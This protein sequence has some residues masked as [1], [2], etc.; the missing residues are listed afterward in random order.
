MKELQTNRWVR[1]VRDTV[2]H[3]HKIGSTQKVRTIV[4]AR[5]YQLYGRGSWVPRS[6][7]EIYNFNDYYEIQKR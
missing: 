4:S 7:I 5:L 1:I 2:N 3:G 6:N